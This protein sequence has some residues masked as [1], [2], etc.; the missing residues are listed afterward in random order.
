MLDIIEYC[1]MNEGGMLNC[2]FIPKLLLVNLSIIFHIV[3][4]GY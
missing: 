4:C 1:R 2:F 3:K